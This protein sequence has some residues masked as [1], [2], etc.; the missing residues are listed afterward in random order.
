MLQNTRY[1]GMDGCKW[2]FDKKGKNID[3][4]HSTKISKV[5]RETKLINNKW[6]S[7]MNS[8]KTCF[9]FAARFLM[10]HLRWLT[11]ECLAANKTLVPWVFRSRCLYSCSVEVFAQGT[12]EGYVTE[13]GLNVSF[14]A[15][16]SLEL[17]V[18]CATLHL[19]VVG[20]ATSLGSP[21]FVHSWW[22]H[23]AVLWNCFSHPFPQVKV[24]MVKDDIWIKK[25]KKDLSQKQFDE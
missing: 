21:C 19:R 3:T 9:L 20:L 8:S 18:T 5:K 14:E 11:W 4:S 25:K 22:L 12:L 17:L 24:F 13:V 1:Y 6:Q 23:P 16:L 10:L 7:L 15:W 2:S